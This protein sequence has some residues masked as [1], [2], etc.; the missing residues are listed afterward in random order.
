M[1]IVVL[2]LTQ[3][4]T[5]LVIAFMT[6]KNDDIALKDSGIP[7]SNIKYNDIGLEDNYGGI[8]INLLHFPKLVIIKG[9]A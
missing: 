9:L 1:E 7:C 6:C 4:S 5:I 8:K 3:S 2:V